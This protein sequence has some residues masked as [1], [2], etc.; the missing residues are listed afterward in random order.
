MS[1]GKLLHRYWYR[2]VMLNFAVNAERLGRRLPAGWRPAERGGGSNLT[3]GLCE[4]TLD[5]SADGTPREPRSYLYV[6]VNGNAEGPDGAKANYRYMTYSNAPEAFDGCDVV[7]TQ[8][9][10]RTDHDATESPPVTRQMYRFTADRTEIGVEITYADTASRVYAGEMR[11]RCPND[12]AYRRVYSNE[13]IQHVILNVNAKVDLTRSLSYRVQAS[14]LD[15]LF[16]GSERLMS[17]VIVPAS[18][19]AVHVEEE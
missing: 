6:P 8:A 12:P 16:D 4:V 11:V 5:V 19:R 2:R 10:H 14:E 9:V 1:A 18:V 15:E 7:R 17:I 3:V 13:E